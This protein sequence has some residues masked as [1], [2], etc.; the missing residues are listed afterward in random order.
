V[1]ILATGKMTI[2]GREN[3]NVIKKKGKETFMKKEAQ[4]PSGTKT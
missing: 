3:L 1:Q 4:I 2:R